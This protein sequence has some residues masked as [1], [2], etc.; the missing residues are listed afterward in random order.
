MSKIYGTGKN[1]SAYKKRPSWK[2]VIEIDDSL[3]PAE[4]KM[5]PWAIEDWPINIELLEKEDK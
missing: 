5:Q 2:L 1:I 4:L 3:V